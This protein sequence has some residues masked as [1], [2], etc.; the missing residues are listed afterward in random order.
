KDLSAYAGRTEAF[1]PRFFLKEKLAGSV[2]VVA[3]LSLVVAHPPPL[4]SVA[5]STTTGYI[6]LPAWYI[7]VL[8]QLVKYEFASGS[9][10]VMGILVIPG[11]VFG[12]LLLAPFLDNGPGRRPT[13]RPIAVAMMILAL[14]SVVWLTYESAAAVDW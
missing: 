6:P 4:E 11:L 2:F 14:T 7:L 8:Y 12:A 13:Q 1:W 3:C 9:Y 5:D 10:V